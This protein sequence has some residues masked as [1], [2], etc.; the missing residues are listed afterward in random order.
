[1]AGAI[2][3]RGL[4][5]VD[6]VALGA[7]AHAELDPKID[8]D[9]DKQH[10]K[11]YRYGVERSHQRQPERRRYGE[12]DRNADQYGPDNLGRSQ[13]QPQNAQQEGERNEGVELGILLER[14]KLFVLD[15]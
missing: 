12:A 13:R 2:R 8:P 7:V 11:G 15:G 10:R 14:P 5:V 3:E 4:Q 1:M 9:A 6:F